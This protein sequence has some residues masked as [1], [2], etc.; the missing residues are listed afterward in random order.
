MPEEVGDVHSGVRRSLPVCPDKQTFRSRLACL[1][2]ANSRHLAL[3]KV[4]TLTLTPSP[5]YTT[6]PP[7]RSP[8]AS[9]DQLRPP[10]IKESARSRR[11]SA[12]CSQQR[13]DCPEAPSPSGFR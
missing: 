7:P 4:R 1:K 11:R 8:S 2:G 3:H 10:S 6:P 13:L 12:G 9:L 5:R